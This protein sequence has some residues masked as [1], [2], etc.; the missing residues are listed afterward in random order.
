MTTGPAEGLA[1]EHVAARTVLLDALDALSEHRSS[2][3]VVG[4]QAVYLRTGSA[5][6][7]TAPFTTDGDVT[8]DPRTLSASPLLEEA[9][10]VAGFHLLERPRGVEPGTWVKTTQ[11]GGRPYEVP[12]DLI[13]PSGA[14]RGGKTRG[15]RL[16]DHGKRAAKRT[17]GLEAAL[18]DADEMEIRGA[19]AGDGRVTAVAVAGAAALLV[20]KVVKISERAADDRRP[21]RQKDKDA[22]D[23]L[24]L[25]RTTPVQTMAEHLDVLRHDLVAGPVTQEALAVLPAL[26]AAPASPGVVMAVRAVDLDVPAA[27]VEVQ[28]TGYVRELT[29]LLR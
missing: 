14:L 12:V 3:V 27:T 23:V 28:M 24:R 18:V 13:V 17:H 1:H 4:A 21:H 20:A 19:A 7:T 15:A 2:L 11:V 16:P 8:L 26:F 25:L 9:M 10:Q 22:A 5:G 6:L 29:R